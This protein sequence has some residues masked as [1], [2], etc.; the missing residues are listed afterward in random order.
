M[1]KKNRTGSKEKQLKHIHPQLGC[2]RWV[3]GS[4][5]CLEQLFFSSRSSQIKG[6]IFRYRLGCA[7]NLAQAENRKPS[8]SDQMV[9]AKS[10]GPII[11]AERLD[12]ITVLECRGVPN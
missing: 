6:V 8:C 7:V 5:P 9:N 1:I 3:A 11:I 12:Q 10:A 4:I 2:A